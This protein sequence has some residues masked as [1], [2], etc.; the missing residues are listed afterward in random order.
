MAWNQLD[1]RQIGGTDPAFHGQ[2]QQPAYSQNHENTKKKGISWLWK[3]LFVTLGVTMVC[4]QFFSVV[5][6]RSLFSVGVAVLTFGVTASIFRPKKQKQLH[7]PQEE[8]QLPPQKDESLTETER[9]VAEGRLY[10]EAI[11]KAN[12]QIADKNTVAFQQIVRMETTAEK[13][14]DYI[15]DHP[16]DAPQI[17]KFMNYYLPTLL[18]LLESYVV[19]QKQ[20]VRGTNIDASIT[21]IEGILHTMAVAFE[22]QLDHL[23]EDDALDISADITVLKNMLAQEGLMD[24]LEIKQET[25]RGS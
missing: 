19:L 15:T 23:F 6:L 16:E 21:D 11:R 14:F 4:Y 17:R 20:G 1:G 24:N 3:A 10:L 25:E 18:K 12:N 2:E 7:A 22:K 8:Q 9:I 13:I 5:G